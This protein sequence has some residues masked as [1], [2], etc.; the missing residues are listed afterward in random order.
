[1]Q[2][3]KN[4]YTKTKVSGRNNIQKRASV[5]DISGGIKGLE[6]RKKE[7]KKERQNKEIKNRK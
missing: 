7:R 5:I 4:K 2:A 1:M 3:K 6:E